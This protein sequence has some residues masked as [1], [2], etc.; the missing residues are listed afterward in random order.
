MF[1]ILVKKQLSLKA[2]GKG[3]MENITTQK[4]RIVK[5]S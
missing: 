3:P 4:D 5:S 1:Q 2:N